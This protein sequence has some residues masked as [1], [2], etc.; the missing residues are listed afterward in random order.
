VPPAGEISV[1]DSTHL[2]ALSAVC[3]TD[4]HNDYE[5]ARQQMLRTQLKARGI[6]DRRVLEAMSKV[7]RE[8]FVPPASRADAYAD[9]ALAIDCGQTISQPYIV[10]LMTQALELTGA[11]SV[12]EVGTGSGYQ[13]AILAE[14][15]A[16]VVTVERH[17]PLSRQAEDRLASLG[18]KNVRFVVGDGTLGVPD[19]APMDRIIVTAM[20]QRVP[21]PLWAQLAERGVLV[22][23]LGMPDCQM[24]QAIRKIGGQPYPEDLCPCRFVPLIGA[25][26]WPGEHAAQ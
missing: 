5:L 16:R 11:E 6:T 26:A 23:P 3:Q 14:L 24:L 4:N 19:E 25:E 15:A 20:A 2:L 17:A 18:Y 7:P 21:G 9:R 12:L 13:T 10:G 1:A 22:I 8:L